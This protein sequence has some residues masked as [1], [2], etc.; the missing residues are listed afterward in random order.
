LV[1]SGGK[2][3]PDRLGVHA[4]GFVTGVGDGSLTSGAAAAGTAIF[5]DA[6]GSVEALL[7]GS[8]ESAMQE[9]NASIAIRLTVNA[10]ID[11]TLTPHFANLF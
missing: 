7:P 8:L 4:G 9:K 10:A 6:L 2:F 1:V 3:L 5:D 11:N